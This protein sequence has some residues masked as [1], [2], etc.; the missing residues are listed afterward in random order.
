MAEEEKG[1]G[2][3]LFFGGEVEGDGWLAVVEVGGEFA[4]DGGLGNGGFVA[5]FGVFGAA[6]NAVLNGFQVG[7]DEFCGDSF[8]VADGVDGA[9]DVVDVWIVKTA[10]D[11]DDGVNLADVAEEFVAQ[12]FALGCALDE[13]SDVYEFDAGWD[14]G[15]GFGD[16]G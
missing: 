12:S 10:N 7:E 6:G 3:F 4:E 5:A 8:Y 2:D 14:Y 11:L 13:A 15:L 9:G 16:C 1:L